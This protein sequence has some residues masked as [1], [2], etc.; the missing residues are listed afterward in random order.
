LPNDATKEA[1]FIGEHSNFV[2]KG[3]MT[4]DYEYS[5]VDTNCVCF[6]SQ[7]RHEYISVTIP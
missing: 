4:K 6:I 5:I 7:R 1:K 2:S 3:S